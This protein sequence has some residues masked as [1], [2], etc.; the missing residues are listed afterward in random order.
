MT[1]NLKALALVPFAVFAIG[2]LAAPAAQA[3][4]E[5]FHC[6]AERCVLTGTTEEG[7]THQMSTG[8]VTSKCHVSF[9]ATTNASTVESLTLIPS[10][11]E[12]GA[13][14]GNSGTGTGGEGTSPGHCSFVLTSTTTNGTAPVH[15][16]CATGSKMSFEMPGICTLTIGEQTPEGGVHYANAAPGDSTFTME[17]SLSGIAITKSGPFC[18][19]FG[20][21]MSIQSKAIFHCYKDTGKELTGTEKTTPSG[22]SEGALANCWHE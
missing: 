14:G 4:G 9:Q 21:V 8:T 1:R 11:S 12:C 18:S 13:T 19:V 10:Y 7:T 3:T 22:T 2:A 17:L 15:I 16:E 5:K 6:E 20:S